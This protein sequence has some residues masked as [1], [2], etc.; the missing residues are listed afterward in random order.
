MRE[1]MSSMSEPFNR[2]RLV[3]GACIVVCF[4]VLLSSVLSFLHGTAFYNAVVSYKAL[5]WLAA[6]TP[7]A[8]MAGRRADPPR[9]EVMIAFVFLAVVFTIAA[10]SSGARQISFLRLGMYY[11]FF[12]FGFVLSHTLGKPS[13]ST[14]AWLLLAIAMVH[15]P[16][17][18]IALQVA[19]L[20]DP[21]LAF[22][23]P[24]FG[25]V[26]HLGYLGFV[27]GAASLAFL[28]LDQRLRAVGILLTVYALFGVI[29][30]GSRGALVAWVLT[31]AVF[32]LLSGQL[33][34][35]MGM[36]AGCLGGAVALAYFAENANIFHAPGLFDRAV[37]AEGVFTGTVGRPAVWLES[38]RSFLEQ[39]IL[40]YGPEG[41]AIAGVTQGMLAQPHN[42]VLQ[43]LLEAGLLGLLAILAFGW[44]LFAKRLQA[45][46]S[47]RR[48][49]PLA[50]EEAG[51]LAI[52]AGFFAFGLIDGVFYH[53]IPL[54]CF[55]IVLS[56]WMAIRSPDGDLSVVD[57]TSDSRRETRQTSEKG[58]HI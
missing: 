33:K 24:Y 55:V 31:A 49:H 41:F 1:Y 44:A 27:A 32:A 17:L 25:N 4:A 14:V 45:V 11:S 28:I 21:N 26:R 51:L 53:A 13:R 18:A 30:L 46:A 9:V 29:A 40:G 10:L 34:R 35:V 37:L 50:D 56:A 22:V 42:I 39:P 36:A 20:H 7:V 52:M 57:S 38:W 19:A 15:A 16:F 23:P 47:S 58:S 54:L 12:A 6:L 48:R 3:A 5:F 2:E 8:L 43:V